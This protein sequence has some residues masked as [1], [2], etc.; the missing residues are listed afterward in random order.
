MMMTSY[1]LLRNNKESGP[2]T[3]DALM[4]LGLKAY[5]L[6]WVQ[7]KSAAWRYPSEVEELKG[8][9]PKV[10]EQPF[11]RF[12]K[13]QVEPKKEIAIESKVAETA[14]I[15]SQHEKYLPKKS[16]FVTLPGQTRPTPVE[17][18][19]PN[20]VSN[21]QQATSSMQ[22]PASNI[23]HPT[24]VP[25]ISVSENPAAAQIK[26]SQ[27]LDEIK[28]MYVKT[29][30]DRKQKIARKGFWLQNLKKAAALLFLVGIG[31]VAGLILKSK[32]NNTHDGEAI[33]QNHLPATKSAMVDMEN[34]DPV[35]QH[36]EVMS[37]PTGGYA[38]KQ[39]V[40]RR[41]PPSSLEQQPL[42]RSFTTIKPRKK[43]ESLLL[44][45]NSQSETILPESASVDPATGERTRKTRNAGSLTM[46][47]IDNTP[48][49]EKQEQRT[50]YSGQFTNKVALSS[51]DYK[52]VPFGGIRNLELTVTNNTRFTLDNVL[53]EV[54]YLKPSEEPLR[55]ETIQFKGVGPNSTSTIRLP[56]TNRGI[57]VSY[58]ILH[59]K[60]KQAEDGV[61]DN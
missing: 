19:A 2:Y 61:A 21:I 11:D 15:Q 30:Q 32:A 48:K 23:Q 58:R 45:D 55:T 14:S 1:L 9:A 18:P 42:D 17:R 59:I 38:N 60:S 47:S 33:V 51:N 25:A 28:E 29:L 12:S 54:Q 10:E 20:P 4:E 50:N 39:D 16:V 52:K 49:K 3:L 56:D 53:V 31:V 5:D 27:P 36:V 44:D 34:T 13:T 24:S 8:I 57:K 41:P 26:Y 40:S 22:H 6:I 7:G 46:S 37:A 43:Q 35:Q